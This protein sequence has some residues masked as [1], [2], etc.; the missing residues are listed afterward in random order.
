V[1]VPVVAVDDLG[2]VDESYHALA[3]YAIRMIAFDA[4]AVG[5]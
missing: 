5:N 3:P 4:S 2:A 1:P